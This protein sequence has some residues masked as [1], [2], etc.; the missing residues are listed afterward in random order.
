MK[1][2]LI[3]LG[4]LVVVL[5]IGSAYAAEKSMSA[6]EYNGITAF[7]PVSLPS[8]DMGPGLVLSNGI[9]AFD[10]RL[11]EWSAEGSAAGGLSTMEVRKLDNGITIFDTSAVAEPN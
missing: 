4:V 3:L 7:A 2:I 8:H 6:G 10:V 1:K 5:T 11:A 9:T